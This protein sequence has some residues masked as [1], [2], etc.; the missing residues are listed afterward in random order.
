[1]LRAGTGWLL[2]QGMNFRT[3]VMLLDVSDISQADMPD[4][5]AQMTADFGGAR[6]TDGS[7]EEV[8]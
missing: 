5:A 8:A 6:Q 7:T 2:F 1:M 3:T 4:L